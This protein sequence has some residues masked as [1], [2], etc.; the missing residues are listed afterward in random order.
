VSRTFDVVV[1]GSGP[2]GLAAAIV[3]AQQGRATCLIEAQP[4]IG[5]GLRSAELTAPGFVNDVCA[6][7][8]PMGAASP[9]L[10]SLPLNALGFEWLTPDAAAAHPLDDGTAAILWN[11]LGR[12]CGDLGGDGPAWSRAIGTIARAWHDLE[13]DILAPVG[14]PR[15]PISYSRFGLGAL[16]TANGFA[17]SNFD[18]T[19]ARALF[20]GVAA[21]GVTPF[22]FAG[23]A[24][25]GI[26]LSATAHVRGWPVVRGGSQRLA[27]ALAAH[28]RS[29]G[30]EIV[31]GTP[32]TRFDEL[33]TA[34]H[35][36]FDTSPRG[37]ATILGTRAPA[38]LA[39]VAQA[40]PHGPGVFKVDWALR[41]P[42]PWRARDCGEAATVHVGGTLEEIAAA[43]AAPWQGE[44]AVRPYVLLTQPSLVDPSRAPAGQHTAWAY[45]HVPNGSTVDMTDRIEAQVERF[46]PGFRDVI[47]ARAVR[48][49]QILEAANA[50]LVGGDIG[51]GAN[52]LMNLLFRPTWR[53]YDTGM[54]NVHLC[55]ASTPPGGGVHGMCGY[56]AASRVLG[57]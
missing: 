2:N 34:T 28:F 3:A 35:Y 4:T 17:R 16:R 18:T 11:D 19:P 50:N 46:A 21:H 52:T 27:D 7:V 31:T 53:H 29:L 13:A 48:T 6:S 5:G 37:L 49:P 32:I 30:G 1:I 12:T 38:S 43:E 57:G 14:I 20:A 56:H 8:L 39:R 25:V 9:F 26:V 23:S 40:F 22:S 51:G 44:H 45:C 41:E 55:S 10:R 15:H 54:P 42:I 47:I 36:F 33:P 24:A